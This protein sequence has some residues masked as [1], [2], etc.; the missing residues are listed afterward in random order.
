MNQIGQLDDITEIN[1]DDTV[2]IYTEDEVILATIS[3]VIDSLFSEIVQN[4][5]YMSNSISVKDNINT[6]QEFSKYLIRG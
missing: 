5:K 4:L 1:L 6:L 3:Q 2:V